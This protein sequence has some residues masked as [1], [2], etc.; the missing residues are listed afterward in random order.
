MT[1]NDLLEIIKPEGKVDCSIKVGFCQITFT[2][3]GEEAK[4]AESALTNSTITETASSLNSTT[5]A[6][7]TGAVI[8][9]VKDLSSSGLTATFEIRFKLMEHEI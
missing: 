7:L 1:K 5:A 3:D 2:I 8:I 4:K 9:E 6:E